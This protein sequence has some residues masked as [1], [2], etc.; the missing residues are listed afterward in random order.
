MP[1]IGRAIEGL[2]VYDRLHFPPRSETSSPHLS[3]RSKTR[4]RVPNS[5]PKICSADKNSCRTRRLALTDQGGKCGKNERNSPNDHSD[6]LRLT[7]VEHSKRV[8]SFTVPAAL[9]EYFDFRFLS[10]RSNKT[11]LI[12]SID[13]VQ[14]F[15]LGIRTCQMAFGAPRQKGKTTCTLSSENTSLIESMCD[16]RAFRCLPLTTYE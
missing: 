10:R 13:L 6:G 4:C 5:D 12:L 8:P 2:P 1:C 14:R 9:H 11:T 15:S 16:L 7:W 3:K